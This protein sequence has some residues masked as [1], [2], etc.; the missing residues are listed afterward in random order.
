MTGITRRNLFTLPSFLSTPLSGRIANTGAR[1]DMEA[2]KEARE[3]R[4]K[5]R[6]QHFPNVTLLTHE[7]KPVKFYDDLIKG[8]SVMINVMYATCQ[9][10]CPGITAN[11]VNVQKLLGKRVGR[12]I[13]MYSL[14]LKPEQDSP[15]ALNH[16]RQMHGIG[17]GWTL[18]TGKPADVELL[19]QKLG[20][21]SPNPVTDKDTSQHIGNVR[22]GNEP[23]M[24]WGACPGS[25]SP[26]FMI[27][28]VSRVFYPEAAEKKT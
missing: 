25:T 18:L 4:E 3:A 8:K 13:F 20:F 21:T 6:R 10:V 17:P 14:T 16:Y 1:L 2:A 28:L 7:G 26:K 12:E 24:L 9:G 23:L 5:I 15:Q 19:R 27:E 11:L 22:Y